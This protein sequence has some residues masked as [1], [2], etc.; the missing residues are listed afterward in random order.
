VLT[1]FP[2]EASATSAPACVSSKGRT[3]TT[4][5]VRAERHEHVARFYRGIVLR[6]TASDWAVGDGFLKPWRSGDR[7]A[8]Q[9]PLKTMK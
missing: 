6:P 9:F 1:Q 5:A 3:L 8:W 4:L 7:S 2:P